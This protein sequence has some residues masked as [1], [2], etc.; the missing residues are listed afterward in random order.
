M[1]R[2]DPKT[3][4]LAVLRVLTPEQREEFAS[5]AKTEVSYLYALG[6]CAR[7]SPRASLAKSIADASVVLNRRHGTPV[8]TIDQLAVMC[9]RC[10]P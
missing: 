7:R 3:P 8:V 4:L 2:N 9:S 6:T 1:R 5:E 10:A